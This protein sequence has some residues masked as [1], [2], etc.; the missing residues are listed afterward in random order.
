MKHRLEPVPRE[1]FPIGSRVRL[2]SGRTGVVEAWVGEESRLAPA[3]RIRVR[4][5]DDE[6]G[7]VQLVPRYL[8]RNEEA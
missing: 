4:Y 8:R 7:T 3:D 6:G 2:P 5:L 1:D